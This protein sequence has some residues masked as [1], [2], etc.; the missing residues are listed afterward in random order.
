MADVK[1]YIIAELERQRTNALT[2]LAQSRGVLGVSQERIIQL[3]KENADLTVKVAELTET[4]A[5]LTQPQ[6]AVE[7]PEPS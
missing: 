2:E 6:P 7:T 4:A 1:D 5:Q 3:E